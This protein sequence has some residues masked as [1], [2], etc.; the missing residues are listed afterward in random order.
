MKKIIISLICVILS[1]MSYAQ[2][3]K[4]GTKVRDFIPCYRKSDNV[5]GMYDL[6]TSSFYSSVG[7]GQFTAGS[8]VN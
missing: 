3:F 7:S 5:C 2:I 6:V 8:L 4:N 1:Q